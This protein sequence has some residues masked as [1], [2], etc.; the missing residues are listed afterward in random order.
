M[1]RISP[2]FLLEKLAFFDHFPRWREH[3]NLC[4]SQ[5]GPRRVDFPLYCG[6]PGFYRV[7]RAQSADPGNPWPTQ[8]L[9]SSAAGNTR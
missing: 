3:N 5:S 6:I 1:G 8:H 9:G 2:R 7:V 4:S